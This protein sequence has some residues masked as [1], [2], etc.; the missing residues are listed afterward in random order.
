M[1]YIS[2]LFVLDGMTDAHCNLQTA[3]EAG[4]VLYD[5]LGG[6]DAPNSACVG[7]MGCSTGSEAFEMSKVPSWSEQDFVDHI[8]LLLGYRLGWTGSRFM[9]QSEHDVYKAFQDKLWKK[10]NP[11]E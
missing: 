9:T 8:A 10:R 4:K 3:E 6:P 5:Y 2:M 11:L 7:W 1:V